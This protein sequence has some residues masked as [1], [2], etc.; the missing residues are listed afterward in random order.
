MINIT[1]SC[2]VHS[3]DNRIHN[4]VQ[5][6]LRSLTHQMFTTYC[7]INRILVSEWFLSFRIGYSNQ[8]LWHTY[9]KTIIY[10]I[11]LSIPSTTDLT[12][13]CFI[14][15]N[16]KTTNYFLLLTNSCIHFNTT[17]G[18]NRLEPLHLKS[19]NVDGYYQSL[20]F[21]MTRFQMPQQTP[22]WSFLHHL[23]KHQKINITDC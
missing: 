11:Y 18:M 22:H 23:C 19:P 6:L 21:A 3:L 16:C 10:I 5:Q 1:A 14:I 15:P 4:S 17:L 2:Y 12:L 13:T 9:W 7:G 8:A 20:T